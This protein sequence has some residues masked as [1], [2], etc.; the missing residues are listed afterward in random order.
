MNAIHRARAGGFTLV[1]LLIV[2]IILAILSSMAIPQFSS[3][4]SEAK[5]ATVLR[6]LTTIRRAIELYRIHHNA[7]YP[8]DDFVTQLVSGTDVTGAPGNDYGPYFWDP[9]PANPVKEDKSVRIT[10]LMPS[11]PTGDEGWIYAKTTGD[12]RLNQ[13]GNAPSGAAWF[14]L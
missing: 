9:W 8:G 7:S 12:F 11:A 4:A 6:N 10:S 1:E 2:V 13:T 14:D 5:E 3:A